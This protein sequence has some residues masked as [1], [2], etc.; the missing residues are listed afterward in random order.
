[1]QYFLL[2]FYIKL[3]V[4]VTHLNY[5]ILSVEAIRMSTHSLCFYKEVD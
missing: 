5:L 2:I 3:Y 1:M 4:I